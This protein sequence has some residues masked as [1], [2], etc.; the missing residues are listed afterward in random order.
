MKSLVYPKE[1]VCKTCGEKS[2][3]TLKELESSKAYK[4]YRFI[5]IRYACSV[6]HKQ[7][8]GVDREAEI[9]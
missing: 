6:G 9:E 8:F 4:E 5:P 2:T 1:L 7:W 3:P